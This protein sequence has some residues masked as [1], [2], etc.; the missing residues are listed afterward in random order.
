MW[1]GYDPRSKEKEKWVTS[2]TKKYVACHVF[3][4][5]THVVTAPTWI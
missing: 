3:A 5:T 4:H 1:A 2:E